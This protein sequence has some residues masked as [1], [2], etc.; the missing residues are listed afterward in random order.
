M[1]IAEVQT[2]KQKM[3]SAAT[4]YA[5][6]GQSSAAREHAKLNESLAL[7]IAKYGVESEDKAREDIEG[8]A[9]RLETI[10]TEIESMTTRS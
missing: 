7:E 10:A 3:K 5:K 4:V 9:E 1:A 2:L 8:K 6:S